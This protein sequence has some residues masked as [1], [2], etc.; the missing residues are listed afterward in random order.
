MAT[1]KTFSFLTWNLC[2]MQNSDQAPASWRIDQTE[3]KIRELILQLDPDFVFF[4]ELPG[5]VP[6][7]ETHDLVPANTTSHSGNIATIA[8]KSLMDDLVSKSVA[9]FAV[10]TSVKSDGITFANV[11]LE[12]GKNGGHKRLASFRRIVTECKTPGLAIIGDTNTRL[13]ESASLD[14]IGLIGKR[15]SAA[16]WNSKVNRFRSD[17]RKFTAYFTRYFHDERTQIDNVKVW[18]QPLLFDDR[19]FFLSDH[20][21]LSGRV[22]AVNEHRKKK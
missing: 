7:V 11:H 8:R 4:Q 12:P 22:S 1:Q 3:S 10:L 13:T 2:L 5:L 19:E 6:Y 21:A 17:G 15:P 14:A 20:F 16:T 9:G 18:D